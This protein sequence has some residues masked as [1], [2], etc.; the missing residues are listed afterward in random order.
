MRKGKILRLIAEDR[1]EEAFNMLIC[2]LSKR[3]NFNQETY[4]TDVILL[5]NRFHRVN[6]LFQDKKIVF[7][8]FDVK[9]NQIIFSLLELIKSMD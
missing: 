5:S 4:Q 1:M 3:K 8:E 7:K 6:Y 2:R 9:Y